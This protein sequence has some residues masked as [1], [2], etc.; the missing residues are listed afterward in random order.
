VAAGRDHQL[1]DRLW[2]QVGRD[3]GQQGSAGAQE[4]A[5]RLHPDIRIPLVDPERDTRPIM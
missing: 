5:W 2:R 3:P 4:S 1:G